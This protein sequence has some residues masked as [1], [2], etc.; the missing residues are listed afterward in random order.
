M[1]TK[2]VRK[3]DIAECAHVILSD[4]CVVF[5]TDT[6]FGVG[7]RSDHQQAYENL[8]FAKH[9]PPSKPFPIMVSSLQMIEQLAILN[10]RDRFLINRW[11]PGAITMLFNRQKHCPEYMTNGLETIGV[12]MPDDPWIINLINRVG[13]PLFVP[14]ANQ[15]GEPTSNQF[16]M[17]YQQMNSRVDLI[18]EGSC[19]AGISST[20]VDCSGSS[21]KIVRQGLITLSDIQMSLNEAGIEED[22]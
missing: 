18:V 14:S 17:A 5:P 2:V 22:L 11:M 13:F 4:G 15:S 12:R 1:K 16:A 8:V 6:V 19:G 9:R 10:A 20:V 21:L 3:E 7:A